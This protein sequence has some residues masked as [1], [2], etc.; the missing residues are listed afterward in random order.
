MS[1][2]PQ[3][4]R[5]L[6]VDDSAFMRNTLS[7][8]IMKCSDMQVVGTA[9]NGQD[10]I[11]QVQRTEPDVMT[12]DIDMPGMNG[13]E[14][15][16][17]L[18]AHHPLPIIM[19]SALTEEGASVT[20]QA[21]ERGA[22]DFMAKPMSQA[23]FEIGSIE[24]V[25]AGKVRVAF[26]MRQRLPSFRPH[27]LHHGR[28]AGGASWGLKGPGTRP[29]PRRPN[30][31]QPVSIKKVLTSTEFPLVV[32]GASTGGPNL[33]KELI[34]GIPSTF[35]AGLLIIQHMPKFFTKVFAENLDATAAISVREAQDGDVLQPGVGFVAPGDHHVVISR[36]GDGRARVL[37]ATEPLDFPY[38]PSVDCA[39]TSAAEQFGPT[40]IGLVLTGMGNDGMVGSQRI[41]EHGGT[42]LVQDEATSLM[43]GMPRAVVEAGW[44]DAVLPDTQIVAALMQTVEALR[45]GTRSLEIAQ[46]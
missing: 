42:V 7:M 26:Q 25:L 19:V 15:L 18:M 36:Q 5:V 45:G 33:L 35:P 2:N 22:V 16:D 38:R 40:T 30:E 17:Y 12:L 31:C 28:T 1:Q 46:S 20:L 23:P 37:I 8:M 29:S 44:A 14:V 32:I 6:V 21:L 13:L 11:E 27:G 4:I 39:M 10:A 3:P 41:K 9:S 34:R 43:Y 24:D